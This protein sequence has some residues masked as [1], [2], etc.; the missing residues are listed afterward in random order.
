MILTLE[1]LD[2]L[3]LRQ[4]I[5]LQVISSDCNPNEVFRIPTLVPNLNSYQIG[6]QF[7]FCCI[8]RPYPRYLTC[9]LPGAGPLPQYRGEGG[10]Q[11]G[12]GGLRHL[13]HCHALRGRLRLHRTHRSGIASRLF[14]AVTHCS[15]LRSGTNVRLVSTCP[16]Q[17]N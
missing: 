1:K 16:F 6:T 14:Q 4:R 3:Y 17:P 7:Y 9:L 11:V 5:C 2:I 10:G 8:Q 12:P 13:H 15:T